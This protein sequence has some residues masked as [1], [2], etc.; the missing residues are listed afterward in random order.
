MSSESCF[1]LYKAFQNAISGNRNGHQFAPRNSFSPN[2]TTDGKSL[3]LEKPDFFESS[4][5]FPISDRLSPDIWKLTSGE[6]KSS[7]EKKK[8]TLRDDVRSAIQSVLDAVKKELGI[9]I[10]SVHIT[11]SLTSNLYLHD[12]DIDVHILDPELKNNDESVIANKALRSWM[13]AGKN[14][15]IG[16]HPIELYLQR[17]KFQDYASIG[18]YDFSNDV[19]DTGPD[20]LPSDYNPYEEFKDVLPEIREYG[21]KVAAAFDELKRD[22]IDFNVMSAAKKNNGKSPEDFL[23]EEKKRE[24]LDDMK[25]IRAIKKELVDSR[26]ASS[27]PQ[28][29]KDADDM[30][31]SKKWANANAMFKFFSRYGYLEDCTKVENLIGELSDSK[32]GTN[33]DF[34]LPSEIDIKKLTELLK[35]EEK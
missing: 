31:S 1:S 14:A 4:I 34:S 22:V 20:I 26:H 11:G 7:K 23:I 18:C 33:K 27:N 35:I 12:S 32:K 10:D 30:R 2:G 28:N 6:K 25:K 9:S 3:I 8:Y 5:D 16:K 19:W 13:E 29:K 24:I 15:K 17:N 21:N